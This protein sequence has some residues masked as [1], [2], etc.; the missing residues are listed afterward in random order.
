[1]YTVSIHLYV[2]IYHDT[3]Y[4]RINHCSSNGRDTIEI[5]YIIM[6]AHNSRA[7]IVVPGHVRMYVAS[8]HNYDNGICCTPP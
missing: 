5:K 3:D 8:Y 2:G 6:Y 1:M 7:E 4:T